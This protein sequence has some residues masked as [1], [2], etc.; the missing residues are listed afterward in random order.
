MTQADAIFVGRVV[1]FEPMDVE[2]TPANGQA[3]VNYRIA[4]VQVSESIFL[5]HPGYMYD[6]SIARQACGLSSCRNREPG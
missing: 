4:V 6:A 2:A 5:G 3:K 1:A